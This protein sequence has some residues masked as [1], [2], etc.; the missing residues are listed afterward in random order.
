MKENSLI[1]QFLNSEPE[2]S[3]DFINKILKHVENLES[4]LNQNEHD[5]DTEK[6]I[7]TIN[8][9]EKPRNWEQVKLDALNNSVNSFEKDDESDEH[10]ELINNFDKIDKDE[11]LKN[12]NKKETLLDDNWE[13]DPINI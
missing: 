8:F 11:L 1:N 2:K 10:E 7:V 9:V 13:D 12:L 3:S 5:Y 6:N 4:N